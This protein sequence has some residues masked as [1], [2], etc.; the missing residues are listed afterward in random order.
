MTEED[1]CHR[2][3]CPPMRK[4]PNAVHQGA[5]IPSRKIGLEPF[6]FTGRIAGV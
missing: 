2:V 1:R 5:F 6:R 4:V 3:R